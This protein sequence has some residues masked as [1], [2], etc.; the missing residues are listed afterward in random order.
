M[1]FNL[2]GN[3]P[4]TPA[5]DET[6][7]SPYEEAASSRDVELA[8]PSQQNSQVGTDDGERRY[9]TLKFLL[10]SFVPIAIEV[11]GLA[12]LKKY[13]VDNRNPLYGVG[14]ASIFTFTAYCAFLVARLC[15]YRLYSEKIWRQVSVAS[16]IVCILW[17]A[18]YL[19]LFSANGTCRIDNVKPDGSTGNSDV[20]CGTNVAGPVLQIIW[21][22]FFLIRAANHF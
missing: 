4:A 19:V 22:A 8:Q 14:S 16:C 6:A 21:S 3:K 17:G 15:S 5:G 9:I 12:V 10:T 18:L 13:Q 1:L 7:N 20:V 11:A 2:G